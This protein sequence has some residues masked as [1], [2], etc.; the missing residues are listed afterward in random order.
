[1][2]IFNVRPTGLNVGNSLIHLSLARLIEKTANQRVSIL[3]IPAS[4]KDS[5]NTPCGLSSSS[6]YEINGSGDGLIVGG[7][8]LFENNE[9]TI[10]PVALGKLSVPNCIFSVS[11]FE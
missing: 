6:I 7:G 9:L 11:G 10:N 1:M 8:N 5:R 3:S 2:K 4:S